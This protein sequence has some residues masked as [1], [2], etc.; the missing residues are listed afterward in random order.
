MLHAEPALPPDHGRHPTAPS[1]QVTIGDGPGRGMAWGC[2]LSYDYVKINAEY[3][4]LSDEKCCLLLAVGVV[5]P[6]PHVRAHEQAPPGG[7]P[8][9]QAPPLQPLAFVHSA[10]CI[11]YCWSHVA[12]KSSG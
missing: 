11:S 6:P 2:D 10:S 5:W 4:T 3:T 7:C 8:P 12:C 9:Q 1:L